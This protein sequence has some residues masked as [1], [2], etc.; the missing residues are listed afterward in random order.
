[1]RKQ[2]CYIGYGDISH[3]SRKDAL[4]VG[5]T[6]K[7]TWA[8]VDSKLRPL[9]FSAHKHRSNTVD[10]HSIEV[11]LSRSVKNT[12]T[13]IS[14]SENTSNL[15]TEKQSGNKEAN[16]V[17]WILGNCPNEEDLQKA[18]ML[19]N[20][21]AHRPIGNS[22]LLIIL[23]AE[24]R[25]D[26]D[27]RPED[28]NHLLE[29]IGNLFDPILHCYQKAIKTA[30]QTLREQSA[31]QNSL[32]SIEINRLHLIHFV[33]WSEVMARAYRIDDDDAQQSKE[34][35]NEAGLLLE[36]ST[37]LRTQ[38]SQKVTEGVGDYDTVTSSI[39]SIHALSKVL[40]SFMPSEV[41]EVVLQP[42][43][44][45]SQQSHAGK[46][47]KIRTLKGDK[48]LDVEEIASESEESSE[49]GRGRRRGRGSTA[50]GIAAA[51]TKSVRY[52]SD[53]LLN[54]A[55]QVSTGT[56]DLLNTITPQKDPVVSN[57]SDS[58]SRDENS[59]TTP[60]KKDPT[61]RSFKQV[62]DMKKRYDRE[63]ELLVAADIK[64]YMSIVLADVSKVTTSKSDD[65]VAKVDL[66]TATET[67]EA[68]T[69]TTSTTESTTDNNCCV[70]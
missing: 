26:L 68:N 67:T 22:A 13:M 55:K 24:P 61:I 25:N 56:T 14:Q 4:G 63:I 52:A 42:E 58:K 37:G 34:L 46:D 12:P 19:M 53:F 40:L 45:E 2:L 9:V 57:M 5:M 38:G 59:N 48:G 28:G 65:H 17:I 10:V 44:E 33:S 20:F 51:V 39:P 30:K 69:A 11:L 60:S 3:D 64:K 41:V 43:E 49:D 35:L 36:K 54:S 31:M 15:K 47:G 29:S 18:S 62:K 23:A 6:A 50:S 7:E 27:L 66:E 70:S 1:M 16:L 21:Q 32:K 8:A